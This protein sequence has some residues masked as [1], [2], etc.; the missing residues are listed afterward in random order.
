MKSIII[1]TCVFLAVSDRH[2][3]QI[4]IESVIFLLLLEP[5][6]VSSTESQSF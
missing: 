5:Y 2:F 3:I 4:N 1:I 6:N